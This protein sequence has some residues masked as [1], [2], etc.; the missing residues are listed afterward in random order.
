MFI[1]IMLPV[2]TLITATKNRH[3]HLSRVVRFV[4]DQTYTGKIYHLIFN[5]AVEHLRLN[6]NLP[7][8][9]FILVNNWRSYS[10]GQ[11]YTT[12][13]EIYNDAITHVPED[14]DIVNMMDDDDIYFPNHVEEGV[15]G[16]LESGK[17]AYKPKKSYYKRGKSAVI[18]AENVLEP[19]I[20]VRFDHIKKYGFSEETT[21]QHHQWISPLLDEGE[22]VAGNPG[23][24]TYICDWSGELPTFKTSGNPHDPDNF[25]NYEK[26]TKFIGDGIITPCSE[27]LAKYYYRLK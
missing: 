10:T 7:G 2:V 14:T 22:I 1:N 16:L 5:N 23:I 6:S 13:G 17:K 4:L 9:K 21:A 11:K 19:S 24:P 12:L 26:A 8:E 25:T 15:K 27:K 20:F 18:L 3:K